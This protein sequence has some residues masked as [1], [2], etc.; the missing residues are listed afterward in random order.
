MIVEYFMFLVLGSIQKRCQTG[1]EGGGVKYF[2][3]SRFKG[4]SKTAILVWQKAKEGLEKV[5]MCV[6]S[7]MNDPIELDVTE[8][9]Q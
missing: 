9:I 6:T 8:R 1:M 4:V 5:W 3:D 7:F 2:C